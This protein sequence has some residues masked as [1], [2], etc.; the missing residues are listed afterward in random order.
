MKFAKISDE[1]LREFSA[2]FSKKV[3]MAHMKIMV[4]T[5]RLLGAITSSQRRLYHSECVTCVFSGLLS[6][7]SRLNSF[8]TS[9]IKVLPVGSL[10]YIDRAD[11]NRLWSL[12]GT[13]TMQIIE[14][15]FF[16]PEWSP[17]HPRQP[18]PPHVCISIC[19]CSL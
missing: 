14:V 10:D 15:A 17:I 8:L 19:F 16:H 9:Q 1:T 3:R 11:W 7:Q 2:A 13:K 12:E 6:I 18:K 5:D 4:P